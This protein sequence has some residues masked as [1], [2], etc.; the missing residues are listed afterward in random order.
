MNRIKPGYNSSSNAHF[1]FIISHVTGVNFN[2]TDFSLLKTDKELATS[3]VF[4]KYFRIVPE[5]INSAELRRTST[6]AYCLPDLSKGLK[7][8]SKIKLVLC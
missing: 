2:F 1:S 3:T 6:R 8:K 4:L 5:Y 7:N